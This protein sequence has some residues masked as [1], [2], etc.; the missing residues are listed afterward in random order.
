MSLPGLT[1]SSTR[2]EGDIQK[3]PT[4]SQLTTAQ[5]LSHTENKTENRIL[6]RKFNPSPTL[7]PKG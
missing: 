2:Q 5:N 7:T 6:G 3:G 1:V 4:L